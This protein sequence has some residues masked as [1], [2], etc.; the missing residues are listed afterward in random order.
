MSIQTLA[1]FPA[2]RS[3]VLALIE[4]HFPQGAAPTMPTSLEQE[5]P[6]LLN[7]TKAQNNYFIEVDGRIAATASSYVADLRIPGYQRPLRIVGIGLVVTHPDFRKQGH[8]QKLLTHIEQQASR[9]GAMI[10]VLWS[11]LVEFYEKQGYMLAGR[12]LTWDVTSLNQLSVSGMDLSSHETNTN[13][14]FVKAI[15]SDSEA[16]A[17][18]SKNSQIAFFRDATQW[19]LDLRIPDSETWIAKNGENKIFASLS[20]GKGRDLREVIH[21]FL[22]NPAYFVAL[23]DQMEVGGVEIKR[24][25]LPPSSTLTTFLE[26]Q[27]LKGQVGPLCFAK[28]IA[29]RAF[30]SFLNENLF[31]LYNL[32]I[33]FDVNGPIYRIQDSK[34]VFFESDETAHL[35]Q[36]ALGPWTLDEYEDLHPLVKEKLGPLKLP[37]GFYLWGFDSV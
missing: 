16:L 28:A 29:P 10:A 21:E 17:E 12:E 30:A 2:K 22:G 18:L 23:M 36:L 19:S 8:S 26:Q 15:A 11:D 35:I 4:E 5:F 25:Q 6:L 33:D 14:Q 13:I 27:G 24:L 32:K 7:P 9:Q 3:E 37:I 1:E 34:G 20:I 31:S